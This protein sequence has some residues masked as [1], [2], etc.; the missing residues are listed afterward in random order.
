M[1]ASIS[2][3]SPP[4]LQSPQLPWTTKMLGPRDSLW[5]L[6]FPHCLPC[7]KP[8]QA[9]GRKSK[10]RKAGCRTDPGCPCCLSQSTAIPVHPGEL[11]GS[12]R[13]PCKAEAKASSFP[14]PCSL[15]EKAKLRRQQGEKFKPQANKQSGLNPTGAGM[16]GCTTSHLGKEAAAVVRAEPWD[17]HLC[18]PLLAWSMPAGLSSSN[19]VPPQLALPLQVQEPS[20]GAECGHKQLF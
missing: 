8:A 14:V 20:S 17:P 6:P 11:L 10:L 1:N 2:T 19:P 18:Q 4:P 16:S 12:L 9:L 15:V 7:R 5:G 13:H 3:N